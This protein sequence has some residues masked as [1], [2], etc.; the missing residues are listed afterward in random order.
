MKKYELKPMQTDS[1]EAGIIFNPYIPVEVTTIKMTSTKIPDCYKLVFDPNM[2][3]TEDSNN[4]GP[5]WTC[6]HRT[7]NFDKAL[8][9]LS[10]GHYRPTLTH[11]EINHGFMFCLKHNLKLNMD[12]RRMARVQDLLDW[13][14][15]TLTCKHIQ[16]WTAI[17][18]TLKI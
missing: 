10:D 13:N 17:E 16:L 7:R 11:S 12:I 14:K 1:G 9:K 6:E 18:A 4:P 2:F 8:L 5:C 3:K 15:A